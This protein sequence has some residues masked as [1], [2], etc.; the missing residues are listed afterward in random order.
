M[1]NVFGR[2]ITFLFTPTIDGTP[3][4]VDSL[5]TARL[6]A[7]APTSAQEANTDTSS[8]DQVTT[9]TDEGQYTKKIVF[10]AQTDSDPHSDTPYEDFYVCVRFKFDSGGPTVF[11]TEKIFLYRPDA[12]TS[13][14]STT[15]VDVQ[16]IERAGA[17]FYV[18]ADIDE[19]I[20]EAKKRIN[21]RFKGLGKKTQR[22]FNLEELNDACAY[23]AASLLCHS[24]YK[25]PET[26]HWKDKA[27]QHEKNYH[28]IFAAT[29]VGFDIDGDDDPDEDEHTSES[30]AV[31]M[32]R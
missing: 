23:L 26:T 1:K 2:S 18:A 27:D 11:A 16:R 22:L 14:I 5:V 4:A 10:S 8:L 28:E 3:V 9:W 31:W 12:I 6:Y 32:S 20:Y 29:E 30:T 25:S 15:I 19:Y 24:L 21:R 7:E 13:R 17:Q